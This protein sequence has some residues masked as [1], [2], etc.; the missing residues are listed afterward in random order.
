MTLCKF[1]IDECL[2]PEL[3]EVAV[4]RGYYESSCVRNRGWCGQLDH[5][6]MSHVLHENFILVTQ[7]SVDFRGG[8]PGR[9]GGHHAKHEIHAGLICLNSDV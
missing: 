9:L 8:G 4:G 5:E 3:V 1:L 7:N 2:T 6:I